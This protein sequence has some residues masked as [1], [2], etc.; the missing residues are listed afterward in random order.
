MKHFLFELER[1]KLHTCFYLFIVSNV[2]QTLQNEPNHTLSNNDIDFQ[3]LSD[4][5]LSFL[6]CLLFETSNVNEMTHQSNNLHVHACA[7]ITRLPEKIN[8]K[9][10]NNNLRSHP[11]LFH[12]SNDLDL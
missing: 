8:K 10:I 11:A 2:K 7:V 9:I 6:H 1:V 4:N 12:C 3:A 5:K